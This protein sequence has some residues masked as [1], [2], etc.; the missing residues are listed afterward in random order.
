MANY[1]GRQINPTEMPRVI[2]LYEKQ[3]YYNRCVSRAVGNHVGKGTS[4]HLPILLRILIWDLSLALIILSSY[5]D[6]TWMRW[7]IGGPL[8]SVHE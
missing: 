6:E 2:T 3:H 1:N 8:Y 4:L 5:L 7:Q